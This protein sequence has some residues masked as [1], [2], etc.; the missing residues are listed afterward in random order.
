MRAGDEAPALKPCLETV[1]PTVGRC[2]AKP[3]RIRTTSP[4]EGVEPY[5]ASRTTRAAT[6]QPTEACVAVE[7]EVFVAIPG[8]KYA[9]PVMVYVY[10]VVSLADNT[11]T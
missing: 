11:L 6:I 3:P 9:K 2:R 1:R 5:L 10:V 4:F 8:E 7:D